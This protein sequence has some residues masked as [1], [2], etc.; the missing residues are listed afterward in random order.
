MSRILEHRYAI[1]R[2]RLI[3]S[4]GALAAM[5]LVGREALA[6]PVFATYP[7]QLGVASGDPAPDGFVIWTRLAP[8][9][10]EVGYG[11]PSQ[12][13]EVQWEVASDGGFRTIVQKGSAVARP[14][15][16]HSV[17]VEVAGLEP[18]R[19]YWYRFLAGKERS[20]TGRARTM[21][22]PGANLARVR[23][24]SAGCQHYEQG[25]FTAHRKLAA[26]PD[27]D[28]IF[29]YG[30]YIYEY[31]GERLWNSPGGPVEN[32][33]RHVG[34]EMYSLDDYRRRYAQYKMDADLQAAHA[35]AAW[36]TTWDDHEIDNN[37]VGSIDQDGTSPAV[38]NLRRQVAAQAY[39][40]NMPLRARSFPVGPSLQLYRKASY[41]NLL[42]LN[43]LDTRQYRTDQPCGDKWG[44][45]CPDLNREGAEVLGAAQE[46]WL[47]ES[48]SGS[49]A[50]WKALAQQIM[51]MDLDRVPDPATYAVNTDSW[52]GYDRPR[53]RL[54]RFIRDRRIE[55]AVVLTGDEHQNYAGE[56][57]LDGRNPEGRPIATEFV[58]TSI[59]SGGN[60]ND[61]RPDMV[62]I[63]KANPQLKF[64]NN[65]R[66]YLIC[67]V[68]PERWLSEF[69]VLDQVMERNGAISTRARF[70]VAAGDPRVVTA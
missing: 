21:P 50:R 45:V 49:R 2:R 35:A 8:D 55:N 40:E 43:L 17:H 27:L 20:L 9:P 14:E 67:D 44:A 24:A 56:L 58:A 6:Q 41:G 13:V 47:T 68:T 10:L 66:G 7:F 12:P 57:H 22:A 37:W 69:R 29:C 18:A 59:S 19:P 4:F 51:V 15:L 30:D 63:Q 34:G 52:A 38:F 54:L 46:R 64:N 48:L 61:Q 62:E 3:Q 31:R 42:D 36:F 16:G 25:L 53:D 1:S 60:G 70:A 65:Q 11:M 32:V 23:F 33:R 28:F 39:Y 5:P 26:E